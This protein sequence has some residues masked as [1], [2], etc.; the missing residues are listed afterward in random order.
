NNGIILY[1]HYRFYYNRDSFK[2]DYY[3]G[4]TKLKDPENVLFDANINS[5]IYNYTPSRPAGVDADYTWGGWYT[6]SNLTEAYTFDKMPSNN[7]VLYAK[8]V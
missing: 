3:Y 1:D 5:A 6:D 7:L 8:W 2:I 4:S